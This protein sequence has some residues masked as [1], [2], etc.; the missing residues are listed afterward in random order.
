MQELW[1]G[2][3]RFLVDEEGAT[4]TEYAI[5]LALIIV[6]SIAAITTLGGTVNET[7]TNINDQMTPTTGG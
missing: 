4:A 7:F 3:K 2:I 6:V 5:M 1:T